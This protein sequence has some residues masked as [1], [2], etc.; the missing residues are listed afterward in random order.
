MESVSQWWEGLG[1]VLKVYWGIAVPFT[2]FFLLQLVLS[3][4][5]A[6]TPDDLPDAEID[7]DHGIGFQ[8]FT[9]KNLI[10]FFTIFGWAGVAAV[11]GGLST[12]ASVVVAVLAGLAM[13]G[14]MAGVFYLL[15]KANADGTMKLET[16]VGKIGEVYLPIPANRGGLGKVQINVG[17]ALRTLEALSDDG[18]DIPTGKL[19]KV[20]GVVGTTLVVT[21]SN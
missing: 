5:G 20:S 19:I 15:M 6:E 11:H 9:L 16:A 14:I 13:M 18:Q 1:F 2:V 8:F 12:G 10:G 4:M 3:F 21:T 17:G 7:A